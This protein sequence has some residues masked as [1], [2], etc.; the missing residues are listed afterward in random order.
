MEE[1]DVTTCEATL[2]SR[3]HNVEVSAPVEST[4]KELEP[5]VKERRVSLEEGNALGWIPAV[6]QR[7]P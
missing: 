3:S 5:W 1:D 4:T 7:R 6:P 2:D